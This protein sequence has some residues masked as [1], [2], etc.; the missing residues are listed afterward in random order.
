[1]SG[2]VGGLD[3][4]Q[5]KE[6]KFEIREDGLAILTLF[7]PGRRNA[8][9]ASMN[10]ELGSILAAASRDDRVRCV[11]VTGDGESFCAGADLG[12]G[13]FTGQRKAEETRRDEGGILALALI[14]CRKPVIA[15]INGSAV[16]IGITMALAMDIRIVAE[17]AKIGFV[18]AR[19]GIVPEACSSYI[20][21][22]VV[23]ITKAAELTLTGRIFLPKDEPSLFNHI[24]PKSQVMEKA[25]S[26]GLEICQCAPSS[27]TLTKGMLWNSFALMSPTEAHV[28]ESK[29]LSWCF[30]EPSDS[31]EGVAS[32][33]QKRPPNWAVSSNVGP[34][35]SPWWDA[36][37]QEPTAKL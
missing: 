36:L 15:A 29:A 20:L 26:I 12:S 21:P 25:I 35:V 33:L 16:G 14:G 7:R 4:T 8:F 31:R 19:R 37:S 34:N 24:V 23:G 13:S 18:F 9:T 27:V 17:D 2:V 22:R 28:A 11:I 1:M 30:F 5:L 32:F 10:R 6:T 3:P